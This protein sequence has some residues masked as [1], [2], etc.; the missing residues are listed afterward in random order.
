MTEPAAETSTSETSAEGARLVRGLGVWQATAL[1]VTMVVGAGVFITIPPMLANVAGP[2]ALLGWL[3]AGLLIIC[4]GFVWSE[5]GASLPG[6]GGSYRYLLESYGSKTW[7]RLTAFLFIWQFLISAPL[8]L[9][10][11]LIAVATFAAAIHPDVL[12][13]N[14]SHTVE[15]VLIAGTNLKMRFGPAQVFA[16]LLGAVLIGLQYRKVRGVGNLTVALWVG[17][18]GCLFWVLIEGLLRFRPEIAFDF[19]H[20]AVH[21]QD[22]PAD[23]PFKLGAVMILALYSY[24]GYYNVCYVGDEVREPSRTIPRAILA[25]C[26]IIVVLFVGVHLAMLGTVPWREV[27]LD[28]EAAVFSLPAEFMRRIHGDWAAAAVTLLLVWCCAGSVFAGLLGSSRV[29]YGAAVQGH[30]FQS[31]AAV[32]P[33]H[34]F[35]H[36]SL[37]LMGGLTLL[38]SFFDLQSIIN[39]LVVTRILEQFIGQGVGLLILRRRRPDIPRPYRMPLYP[40]P[41]IVALFGWGFVY[42]SSGLLYITIAAVTLVAGVVAFGIWSHRQRTWPFET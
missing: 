10:S 30:F 4:D 1:N 16:F 39:A 33:R 6:S 5:L 7:G 24:F 9:G 17:V 27:P 37:L 22:P 12:A 8:E 31:F 41:C 42:L 28:D 35:P 34:Q 18:L 40:L 13:F 15:Y 21:L 11:G 29:P 20:P 23:L 3:L 25:S 32:H 19:G 26:L 36:R 38:W 2:W 14:S